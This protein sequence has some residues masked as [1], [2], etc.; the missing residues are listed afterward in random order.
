MHFEAQGQKSYNA[1]TFDFSNGGSGT[2]YQFYIVYLA[3]GSVLTLTSSPTTQVP[4]GT[5]LDAPS[6]GQAG[7]VRLTSAQG[8]S[9]V[10]AGSTSIAIGTP[11]ISSASG[12]ATPW[13]ATGQYVI[14]YSLE[15]ATAVGQIIEYLPAGSFIHY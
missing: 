6:A 5:L 4:I 15:V 12:Q 11:L 8:T 1:G 9:N 2:G 14:G 7:M 13:T 3:A 10:I